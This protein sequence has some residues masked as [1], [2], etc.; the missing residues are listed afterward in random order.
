MET[1][2]MSLM[3]WRGEL[4]LGILATVAYM[5]LRCLVAGW[6]AED[7]ARD[8][9]LV[10]GASAM[11]LLPA[12]IHP[13]LGFLPQV[14]AFGLG[15]LATGSRGRSKALRWTLNA[16][17]L[18]MLGGAATLAS[19]GMVPS[20][21]AGPSMWP[22]SSREMSVFMMDTRTR[23]FSRG[24]LV[25]FGVPKHEA[26]EDPDAGW[27]AGRYHK[28]LLGLPG[29]RVEIGP[30]DIRVNG[31]TVAH[32]ARD[33]ALQILEH[34]NHSTWLCQAATDGKA[35]QRYTIVWGEPDIWMDRSRTWVV[36]QDQAFV[37]GDNLPESG[38][39]R[40]RGTIP[41][42]WLVGRVAIGD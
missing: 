15:F 22:T 6:M 40:Y 14:A 36:G 8:R 32:C 12:G 28:R 21:S 13:G 3:E 35:D 18:A 39:S 20:L 17:G 1:L 23:G 24:D 29:D 5:A 38:D 11:V 42:R 9:L 25:S 41:L 10:C 30:L 33:Q 19:L 4:A 27:P 16:L 31:T 26:S 37:L 2:A 7:G 34:F